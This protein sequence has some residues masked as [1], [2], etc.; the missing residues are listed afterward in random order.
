MRRALSLRYFHQLLF[1]FH[2]SPA[3]LAWE[4][5]PYFAVGMIGIAALLLAPNRQPKAAAETHSTWLSVLGCYQNLSAVQMAGF[6]LA[7]FFFGALLSKTVK[8]FF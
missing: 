6:V 2:A 8:L 5:A 4:V 3:A 7:G 1:G